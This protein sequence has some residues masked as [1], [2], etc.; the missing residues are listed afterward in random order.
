MDY[1]SARLFVLCLVDD[2]KPR[3]RNTCD[4]PF[5]VFRARGFPQ[6]FARALALGREQETTYANGKGQS[7]RWV[8]VRVEEIKRLGRDLDGREVGSLLDVFRSDAP[9]PFRRRFRPEKYQ[10]QYSDDRRAYQSAGATAAS[11]RRSA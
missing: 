2:G 5:V 8:F 7:V 11:P 4:Y 6:A 1:Y 3:K 9:I 10:P